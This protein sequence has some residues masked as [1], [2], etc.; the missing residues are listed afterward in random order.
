GPTAGR[1]SSNPGFV[2]G[3]PRALRVV[4]LEAPASRLEPPAQMFVEH[5]DL[6]AQWEELELEP[7][8]FVARVSYDITLDRRATA[9][10]GQAPRHGKREHRLHNVGRGPAVAPAP[11]RVECARDYA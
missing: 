9:L 4:P 1:V 6:G 8:L 11:F 2:S 3:R 5:R 7:A 10:A